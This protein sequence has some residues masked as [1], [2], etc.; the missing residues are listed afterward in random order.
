MTRDSPPQ[1][2][3]GR[4]INENIAKQPLK[5]AAGVVLVKQNM[6]LLTNTTPSAR[7]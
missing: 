2:R 4:D 7:A 5:G 6:R 3:G 1:P